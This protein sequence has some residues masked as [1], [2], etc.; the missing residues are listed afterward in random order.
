MASDIALAENE[1]SC[2][3]EN[4]VASPMDNIID[5]RT[6][7]KPCVQTQEP[8]LSSKHDNEGEKMSILPP[9]VGEVRQRASK[10]KSEVKLS[11]DLTLPP[12]MPVSHVADQL[13]SDQEEELE[14]GRV[15]A[16]ESNEVS[17]SSLDHLEQLTF[18]F[19]ED[20]AKKSDGDA[21]ED[22]NSNNE[23]DEMR[24][25]RLSRP[26]SAPRLKLDNLPWPTILQY[27]RES[28]SLVSEYFS[29]DNKE[30]IEARIEKN[31]KLQKQLLHER[32]PFKSHQSRLKDG[33]LVSSSTSSSEEQGEL[34]EG[35]DESSERYQVCDFCGQPSPWVSLLRMADEQV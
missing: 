22:T 17:V 23:G 9:I 20:Q 30:A 14:E 24:V 25:S 10:D 35:D 31:K 2:S 34:G 19:F 8:L 1:V 27:M 7:M 18:P 11:E 5:D 21:P 28:E 29:I 33:E 6:N 12:I 32:R 26:V 3:S 4:E 13:E 16:V 15:T